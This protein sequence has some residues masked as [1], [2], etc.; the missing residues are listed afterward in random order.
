M[1]RLTSAEHV[2]ALAVEQQMSVEPA[3]AAESERVESLQHLIHELPRE[4][5]PPG[6]RA[7]IEAWVGSPRYK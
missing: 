6:L 2:D 5:A 1:I 4:V 7:R 3:L